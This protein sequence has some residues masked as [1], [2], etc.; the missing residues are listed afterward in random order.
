MAT[1][2]LEYLQQ[3]IIPSILCQTHVFFA[4]SAFPSCSF[5]THLSLSLSF[6][7]SVFLSPLCFFLH[8]AFYFP[9]FT[10]CIPHIPLSFSCLCCPSFPSSYWPSILSQLNIYPSFQLFTVTC[11]CVAYLFINFL[12]RKYLQ[13]LC[14]FCFFL[15]P[16][17][18]HYEKIMSCLVC[19]TGR[20]EEER[21][22][23]GMWE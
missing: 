16:S 10:S 9:H 5:L 13:V 17:P 14:V 22:R 20:G 8:C 3:H 18:H 1:T 12:Y 4:V 6:F 19:F 23:K 15:S 21:E 7:S 2:P 11:I